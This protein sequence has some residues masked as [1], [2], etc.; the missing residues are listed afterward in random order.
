MN[1]YAKP[2]EQ[3]LQAPLQV[4]DAMTEWHDSQ[5]YAVDLHNDICD[6]YNSPMLWLAIAQI[7]EQ[8]VKRE[9][10]L[11]RFTAAGFTCDDVYAYDEYN[12]NDER[13]RGIA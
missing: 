7:T 13:E 5:N 10:A 8:I 9:K 11:A 12:K 2:I 3:I 4:L 1:N 6:R